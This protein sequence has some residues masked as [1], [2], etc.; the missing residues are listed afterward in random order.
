[1][2]LAKLSRMTRRPASCQG[3]DREGMLRIRGFDRSQSFEAVAFGV[4]STMTRRMLCP[5]SEC[6]RHSCSSL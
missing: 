3:L 6:S 2:A 1:M 4:A 5:A